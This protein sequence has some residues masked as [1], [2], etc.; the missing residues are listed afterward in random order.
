MFGV[1]A[2]ERGFYGGVAQSRPSTPVS[3]GSTLVQPRSVYDPSRSNSR[4]SFNKPG[5]LSL[6]VYT[7]GRHSP[8]GSFD[9]TTVMPTSPTFSRLRDSERSQSPV[10]SLSRTNDPNASSGLSIRLHSNSPISSR[11]PPSGLVPPSPR[12]PTHSQEG[13]PKLVLQHHRTNGSSSSLTAG[14]PFMAWSTHSEQ[15]RPV[16]P[17]IPKVTVNDNDVDAIQGGSRR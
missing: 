5:Q 15:S 17:S 10:G 12:S 3:F 7:P 6:G 11:F 14:K 9:S 1:R 4:N 16:S 8:T 2:L 13:H